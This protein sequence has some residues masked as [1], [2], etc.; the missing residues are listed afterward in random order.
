MSDSSVTPGTVARQT[1]L[2]LGFSRQEYWSGL[3]FPSPVDL[4]DPGIEPTS[5]ALADRCLFVCLFLFVL[6][7]SHQGSPVL[8]SNFQ[9]YETLLLTTATV[10]YIT[11]LRTHLSYNWKFIPF[12]TF[13]YFPYLTSPWFHLYEKSTIGKSINTDQYSGFP[14]GSLGK[15]CLQWGRPGF[16]P[17]VRKIPWGRK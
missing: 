2:S 7:L 17:L 15:E 12:V 4:P 13:T 6:P 9:I 8:F 11:I 16:N 1:P 3:P 10:L 5:P 14:D